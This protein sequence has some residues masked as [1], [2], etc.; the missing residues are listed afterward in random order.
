L[1]SAEFDT[2]QTKQDLK[3]MFLQTLMEMPEIFPVPI[4]GQEP[5]PEEEPV[6]TS[7]QQPAFL[8][9]ASAEFDTEQTK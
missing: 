9:L 8:S 4:A 5:V 2:E 1:A 6:A 3:K 7:A